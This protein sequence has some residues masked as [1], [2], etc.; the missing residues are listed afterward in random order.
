MKAMTIDS[1]RISSSS[2]I[3][4]MIGQLW[5]DRIIAKIANEQLAREAFDKMLQLQ[6]EFYRPEVFIGYWKA[7]AS[8]RIKRNSHAG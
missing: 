3:E 6:Y 5:T 2:D 8:G 7:L 1:V 4:L